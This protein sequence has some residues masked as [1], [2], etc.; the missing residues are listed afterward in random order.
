M[1]IAKLGRKHDK[2]TKLKLL[3]NLQAYPITA[4][5]NKTGEIKLFTSIRQTANFIGIHHS[6]LTKCLVTKKFYKGKS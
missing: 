1:R 3:A 6:Y 4:I 5:N 2:A